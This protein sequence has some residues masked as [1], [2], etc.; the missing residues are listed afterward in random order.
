MSLLVLHLPPHPRWHPT[1]PETALADAAASVAEVDFVFSEDG[2]V[3]TERG[4]AAPALL[5][6]LRRGTTQV[7]AVLGECALAWHRVTLPKAPAARLRQA[8]IGL[9]E[10]RL[11][12][13]PQALHFALAPGLRPG[14]RGWVVA[15]DRPW[16]AAQLEALTTAGVEVDR[17][18]PVAA[19]QSPAAVHFE[20]RD[21]SADGHAASGFDAGGMGPAEDPPLSLTW[22]HPDGVLQ[23][24]LT[25]TG[26]GLQAIQPDRFEEAISTATPAASL[27][28]ERWLGRPPA[29][30]STAERWLDAARSDW[31]LRQFDFAP[32]HRAAATLRQAWQAW[33]SPSWRPV[34]WGVALLLVIQVVGLNVQAWQA[35]RHL[36][37]LRAGMDSVLRTAHP[38]VRA[39]LDAPVQ[40]TR[41]TDALRAAA[42]EIGEADLERLLQA[43]AAGWPEGV[44][45]DTLRYDTGHLTLEAAGLG[46]AQAP[47]LQRQLQD[48]GWRAEAQP[49]SLQLWPAAGGPR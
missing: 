42:G 5:P 46:A 30:R 31:N 26:A 16:L 6:G 13:D 3:P 17:I 32:R 29:V 9:I 24:P 23:W 1:R 10:E 43:A 33:T 39:I 28:A 49:G 38:Q 8:L 7:I 45:V 27:A 20:T 15:T 36:R 41:E 44:T 25:A 37:D 12:D 22:S 47:A 11:L 21:E 18:V 48:A 19:P 4:R 34:R 40:M 35:R 14:D 2:Q